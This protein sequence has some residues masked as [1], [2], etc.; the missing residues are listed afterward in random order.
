[1]LKSQPRALFLFCVDAAG[2][3]I[4]SLGD[5]LSWPQGYLWLVH[6][7]FLFVAL[8][9]DALECIIISQTTSWL[10]CEWVLNST[11]DFR[12]LIL[13]PLHWSNNPESMLPSS[14]HLS[15]IAHFLPYRLYFISSSSDSFV[16]TYH[17]IKSIS[18]HRL[19]VKIIWGGH[20]SPAKKN[21]DVFRCIGTYHTL[22][23]L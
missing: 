21:M 4:A 15:T 9:V 5:Q 16:F 20:L 17:G 18:S 14:S 22:C 12:C 7:A 1:M 6:L 13:F 11:G 10:M 8:L 3:T 19:S 2:H 23:T